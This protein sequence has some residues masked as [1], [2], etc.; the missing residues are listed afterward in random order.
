M[1][2]QC[3]CLVTTIPSE[4]YF[5][6]DKEEHNDYVQFHMQCKDGTEHR[7]LD[8]GRLVENRYYGKIF[9]VLIMDEKAIKKYYHL[10]GH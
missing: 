8:Y 4:S 7:V 2:S 3:H 6:E 5:P 1:L 9:Y 10:Q